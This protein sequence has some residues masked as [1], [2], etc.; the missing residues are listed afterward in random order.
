MTSMFRIGAGTGF[1]GDRDDPARVLAA[2][3]D[4]DALVFECLAERTIALAHEAKA[5]GSGRGYDP[6][7]LSRLRDV[8]PDAR[9][10]STRLIT[11]AGAADP[12]AAARDVTALVA[13]L[14]L[15]PTR[16]AAVTGDDVL[17]ALDPA[18]PITGTD[19]TVADLG[20]RFV[21]ANAYL[22]SE[23]I[24]RAIDD[25]A[26]VI[27]TGRVGDAA[28]FAA[29]LL[30]HFGWA[31]DDLVRQ[32]QA[33]VVG[34]LLECAGQLTGG[35]FA[36]GERKVV[37][38]LAR[39]GFP[40]GE[41]D[42]S[43]AAVYSKVDGT[44][45]LITRETVLE[46][47]LYEIDDPSRYLTPDVSLDLSR[48]AIDDLGRDRVRVSGAVPIGKPDRLKVS[49][50]VR[51]GFLA[52]GEISYGGH[53]AVARARM[54]ADIVRERWSVV[55]GRDVAELGIDFGG[56]NATRPWFSI[57]AEPAEVRV[58][59][60]TRSFDRSVGVS[61]A[62]EV[63]ALYTNG[64]AGGGGVVTSQRETI[65]IVSTMIDRDAVAQRV[66]LFS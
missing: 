20:D 12:V 59:F 58:R 9:A 25:G 27:I 44:G 8:L 3:G 29:P 33:T 11:N 5:S 45:G 49:L 43:G 61:L 17:G 4:L 63:E 47:L 35:Y 36:D 15:G 65:G 26:D 16:V 31:G 37:P 13:E 57:D 46:Q 54:A 66:E 28:L 41:V 38:D 60:S 40:I 64:P 56:L 51:D 50:G 21:S 22:G 24:V 6:R 14:N 34:H 19:Q 48:V 42:E 53:R 32:A 10:R 62:H 39:L 23:G 18:S 2:H 7:I 1:A 52:I 55:H 30:H